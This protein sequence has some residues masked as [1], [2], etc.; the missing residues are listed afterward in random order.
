MTTLPN[1]LTTKTEVGK[2]A[3]PTCSKTTS[4]ASPRTVLDALEEL[5]RD[6]EARLLLLGRL[7]PAAHHPGELVAVDE[8]LGA[9]LLDERAL[10]RGGDDAHAFGAGRPAQL[11]GEDAQAAGGAPDEH[12]L[13]GLERR[14]VH[15]HAV[16]GEVGQPVGRRLLPREVRGLGQ[17]L[18]GL[19]LG[20]LR[21]RAPARLVAPDLLRRRGQ[22]IEAV[23]LGV[24]V[25]GLVAVHRRPRR[26]AVQRVTPGPTF[27][28]TP[29]A[30]EPPMW[31]SQSGW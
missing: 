10:L 18:L 31:W 25:G 1:G 13:A 7:A 21:E 23:D 11:G 5:A 28:T 17:Q 6:G 27:H 2:V 29:E 15:Q 19:D 9:E 4:G 20:E 8:A 16:G 12:A 30:S 24:L 14:A 22:R 3:L 26:R